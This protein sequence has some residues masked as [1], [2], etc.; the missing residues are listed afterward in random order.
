[1]VKFIKTNLLGCEAQSLIVLLII[2]AG[3]HVFSTITMATF[4]SSKEIISYHYHQKWR[5]HFWDL[6]REGKGGVMGNQM[7][8]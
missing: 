8:R 7:A 4:L 5:M 6:L 2:Y 1:M 3:F